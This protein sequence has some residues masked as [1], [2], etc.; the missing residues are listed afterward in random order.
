VYQLWFIN[1]GAMMQAFN[2]CDLS[3][4]I[5]GGLRLQSWSCAAAA[6]AAAVTLAEPLAVC[7]MLWH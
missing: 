7:E 6:A 5:V 2:T 3:F 4:G 1:E